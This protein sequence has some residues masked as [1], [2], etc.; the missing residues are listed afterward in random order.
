[1]SYVRTGLV[2]LVAASLMA[3][4]TPCSRADDAAATTGTVSGT[5]VDKDGNPAKKVRVRLVPVPAA[6]PKGAQGGLAA[7]PGAAPTSKPAT[8]TTSTDADGKFTFESV[9]VG[10]Y[11]VLAGGRGVSARSEVQHVKAGE[12]I[13]VDLKLEPRPAPAPK[14]PPAGAVPPGAVG[15]TVR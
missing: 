2:L 1:M 3:V 4:L 14:T 11:R 12:T 6:K 15:G 7:D 5:V 8:L 10:D 9:P 13:N